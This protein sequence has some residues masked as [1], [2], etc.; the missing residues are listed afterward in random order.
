MWQ[1]ITRQNA[2]LSA[3]ARATTAGAAEATAK[4]TIATMRPMP[5]MA[6]VSPESAMLEQVFGRLEAFEPGME[7]PAA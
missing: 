6:T 2:G 7:R 3:R 1:D 4:T 5:V